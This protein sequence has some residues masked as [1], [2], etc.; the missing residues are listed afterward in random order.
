MS[1][2]LVRASTVECALTLLMITHANALLRGT[3]KQVPMRTGVAKSALRLYRLRTRVTTVGSKRSSRRQQLLTASVQ[4][5]GKA[6]RVT[7]TQ[8]SV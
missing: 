5:G 4:Q 1:V 2:Y 6:H 3:H 7:M 8:M